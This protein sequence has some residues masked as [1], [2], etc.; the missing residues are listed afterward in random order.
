[1]GQPRHDGA[2][3]AA[4]VGELRRQDGEGERRVLLA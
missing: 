3:S 2:R 1:M 4:V